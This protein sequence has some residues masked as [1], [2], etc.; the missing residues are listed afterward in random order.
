MSA[1]YTLEECW[2]LVETSEKTGRHLCMMENVNYM[3]DELVIYNMV[4]RGVFGELIHGEGG[5]LHDTRNLKFATVG[6]GLWLG[7]HHALRNGNL[8]PC[9]GIGPL[10]WYMNINHGDRF[11]F[12]VS[13]SSKA[14]GLGLYAEAHLPADDPKRQRKYLNGDVNTCLIRTAN[15]LTIT[16]THDT[17]SPRPYSRINLV[18]GTKG[19][20][21][22]WPQMAVSL[23]IPGNPHPAWLPG[24]KF[25]TQHASALRTHAKEVHAKLPGIAKD[26]GRILEGAV[27]HYGPDHDVQHGDFLEDYRLVEALRSGIAPDFDVYDAATWSSIAVLSEKSVAD[28]SR[29][30]DFPDFTK[31]KWKTTLPIKLMGV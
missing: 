23:E 28:R 7:N 21:S 14:R 9:H 4:R 8:Y 19:L 18:Q 1:A 11:D 12:L 5:Y 20:V 26:S 15:G 25:R 6:D 24:D 22:G 13:M 30:V 17:D 27:W 16:L 10:A 2:Q 31:G 29:P 3:P